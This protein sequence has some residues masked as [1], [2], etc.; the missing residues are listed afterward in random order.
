MFISKIMLR[1]NARASESFWKTFGSEY[2]L[3]QA[4]WDL[5]SDSPN[6]PRDFLYR[7]D[8]V[9]EW[10]V[11]YTISKR[12]PEDNRG[13]WHVVS[14]PYDPK[15][16]PSMRLG[17]TVRVSPTRKRNGKRHDVVM[18]WKSMNKEK[19][20]NGEISQAEV[21]DD[22][23]R[24]WLT[25][26]SAKN[27]FN[28]LNVRSDGYRQVRFIKQKRHLEIRYSIVDFNG[29]LK[30]TDETLFKKMLFDG[31]GSEKGFGCGLMMVRKI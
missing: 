9:G 31:L 15:I 4:V 28:I 29:A 30:V 16:I 20:R 6:R 21:V 18:N 13:L 8:A 23:C 3:H 11:V 27:G 25:E 10:P 24:K 26:R 1:E 22:V 2:A 12:K 5:F 7:L 14:K 19:Y 17:F